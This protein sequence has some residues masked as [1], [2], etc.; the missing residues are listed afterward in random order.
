[1]E[2]RVRQSRA[3]SNHIWLWR[4]SGSLLKKPAKGP[5][6]KIVKQAI[7]LATHAMD[8]LSQGL[9]GL[10]GGNSAETL[11]SRAFR[12]EEG[13]FWHWVRRLLDTLLTPRTL[14]WCAYSY[15]RSLERAKLLLRNK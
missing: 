7:H 4:M 9:N 5:V 6:G 15:E 12:S 1:V 2:M 14:N 10:C 13:T 3:L 8:S 11:S